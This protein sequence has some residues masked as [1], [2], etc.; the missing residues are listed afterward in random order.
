[1]AGFVTAGAYLVFSRRTIPLYKGWSSSAANSTVTLTSLD[2]IQI[3]AIFLSILL[4]Y[5]PGTKGNSTRLHADSE[6]KGFDLQPIS[7]QG[8]LQI[9]SKDIETFNTAVTRQSSTLDTSQ[10]NSFFLVSITTPLLLYTLSNHNC[11]IRPLGAVNTKNRFQFE[12][13]SFCRDAKAILAASQSGKLS[14]TCNFGG[15]DLPGSRRKRGVEFDLVVEVKREEAVVLRQY[16]SVLQFL[17]SKQKPLYNEQ[18]QPNSEAGKEPEAVSKGEGATKI[19]MNASDPRRWAASCSDYN[20]IHI[21][22]LAAKAFGF[23]SSIAHG[24]HAVALALQN[25]QKEMDSWKLSNRFELQVAFVKPMFLPA[26]LSVSWID[27]GKQKQ[28]QIHARDTLV[29]KGELKE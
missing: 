6:G 22:S 12:D 24:N 9:T 20:P 17:P 10:L 27:A 25:T 11:P 18:A 14:Y 23:R 3:S 5:I 15:K 4:K 29:V 28:L 26:E 8:P 16:F 13:A 1:V 2:T 19:R 21:S 7:L